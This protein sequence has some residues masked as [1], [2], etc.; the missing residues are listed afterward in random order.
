MRVT[1]KHSFVG[2]SK[3]KCKHR[4]LK[5]PLPFKSRARIQK[6][7]FAQINTRGITK[8]AIFSIVRMAFTNYRGELHYKNESIC[9]IFQRRFEK[10]NLAT[11]EIAS[12][13]CFRWESYRKTMLCQRSDARLTISRLK[14][15]FI[16]S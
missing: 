3:K 7:A 12:E 2:T 16:S 6:K 8:E 9:V 10:R 4:N 15:H 11:Y 5:A 1:I 13:T 14:V